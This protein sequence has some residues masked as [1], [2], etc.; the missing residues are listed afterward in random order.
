M[1]APTCCLTRAEQDR[2]E[3]VF[4]FKS[5]LGLG[6]VPVP[7]IAEPDEWR[8]FAAPFRASSG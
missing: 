1:A 4:V 8:R 2:Y 3:S 6:Y 7:A 5:F